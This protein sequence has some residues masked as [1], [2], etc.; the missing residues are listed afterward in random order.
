MRGAWVAL[1]LVCLASGS[2]AAETRGMDGAF[3]T[4][5]AAS[6][7]APLVA[8]P[9]LGVRAGACWGPFGV[10]AG[11]SSVLGMKELSALGVFRTGSLPVVVR[12]GVTRIGGGTGGHVGA[13]VLSGCRRVRVRAEYTYR[14]FGPDIGVSTIGVGL[15]IH[16]R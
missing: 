4:V 2:E 11:A 1:P 8:M 7:V 5:E 6:L 14:R 3:V 16:L 15:V 10:E 13:S 12:A 9:I